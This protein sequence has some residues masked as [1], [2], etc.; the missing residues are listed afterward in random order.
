[1]QIATEKDILLNVS[2]ASE[3]GKTVIHAYEPCKLQ[4][5]A[6]EHHIRR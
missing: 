6:Y 3:I 4:L 2:P 5:I 1:M